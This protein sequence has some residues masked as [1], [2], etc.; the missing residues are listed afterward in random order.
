RRALPLGSLHGGGFAG[1]ADLMSQVSL[2]RLALLG[3]AAALLAVAALQGRS[4]RARRSGRATALLWLAAG[5]VLLGIGLVVTVPV[6]GLEHE[7]TGRDHEGLA[8]L[9]GLI[10]E[11]VEFAT[12]GLGILA[13]T[14]AVTTGRRGED[15]GTGRRSSRDPAVV[16]VDSARSAWATFRTLRR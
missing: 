3:V 5:A 14:V 2:L 16:V 7:L 1:M 12:L 10:G 15:A 9:A 6:T 11:T 8:L 13:L 4:G